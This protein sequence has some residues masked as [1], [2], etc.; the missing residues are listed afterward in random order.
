MITITIESN[1]DL[2]VCII[3]FQT[4]RVNAKLEEMKITEKGESVELEKHITVAVV[5][6]GHEEVAA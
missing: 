4:E 1:L 5:E 3:Y 6:N 2:P